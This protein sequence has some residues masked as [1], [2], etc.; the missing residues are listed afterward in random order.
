[1]ASLVL[2]ILT[3]RPTP[4]ALFQSVNKAFTLHLIIASIERNHV[5]D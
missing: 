3:M 1:M 5:P 4:Q 2:R